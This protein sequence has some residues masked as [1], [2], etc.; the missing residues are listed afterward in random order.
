MR[1]RIALP[2]LI[3][4]CSLKGQA[5]RREAYACVETNVA[6]RYV[7]ACAAIAR[8]DFV[9]KAWGMFRGKVAI[10]EIARA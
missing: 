6:A 8:A 2:V 1:A 4:T 9:R 10:D 5:C 7:A 3:G